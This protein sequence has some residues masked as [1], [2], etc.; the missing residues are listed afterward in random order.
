MNSTRK[1]GFTL[2]ELLIVIAILAILAVAVVLVLNPAQLLKQGRDST[3][4]SDMA[5]LNSALAL[6]NTDV[7]NGF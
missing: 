5:A 3:R 4:L 6:F 7:A 2:V 1:L